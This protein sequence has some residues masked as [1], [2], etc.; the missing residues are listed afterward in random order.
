MNNCIFCKIVSGEMP[1]QIVHHD[2]WVTAF[3]D[4]KPQAPTHLL[5]VTNRH[6]SGLLDVHQRDAEL[7]GR[8]VLTANALAR[9][10]GFAA[11]GFRIVSKQ[12]KDG[13]QTVE[14]LHFHLLAGRPV[15]WPPG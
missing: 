4:I 2:E 15:T 10:Q 13:G 11:N 7:L 1:G 14:H 12:G 6:I 9:E 5:I 8:I 3:R